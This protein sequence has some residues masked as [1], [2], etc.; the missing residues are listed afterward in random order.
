[1][2]ASMEMRKA[3]LAAWTAWSAT[4]AVRHKTIDQDQRMAIFSG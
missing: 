3:G 4:K 1:M 2:L